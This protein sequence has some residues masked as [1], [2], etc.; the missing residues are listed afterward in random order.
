MYKRQVPVSSSPI[1]SAV[2][3]PP[4]APVNITI[5]AGTTLTI[6]INQRISVKTSRAGDRFTG[7]IVDSVL[8]GDNRV[9]VPKGAPVGGV[10]DASHRRGHFKGS[11]LLELRLTSMTL[12]GTRYPLATRD[13]AR[14][15]KGKGKRDVYKR[16]VL[17]IAN[18]VAIFRAQ[19]RI[20][21]R[22]RLVDRRVAVNVRH[23]V[24]RCV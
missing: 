6:R 21:E 8:T 11:S 18:G 1:V 15:K 3:Q 23:I 14:S 13:L 5:P 22:D 4:P 2:P 7:E 19:L 12:D 10:V 20:M 24:R 17:G 16:Q 9:L